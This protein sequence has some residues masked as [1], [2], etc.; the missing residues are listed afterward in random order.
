VQRIVQVKQVIFFASTVATTDVD[1]TM[2]VW[3]T[4]Y[5]QL[6]WPY[7]CRCQREI[8]RPRFCRSFEPVLAQ[9]LSASCAAIRGCFQFFSEHP[10]FCICYSTFIYCGSSIVSVVVYFADASHESGTESLR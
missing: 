6:T 5:L 9:A 3:A 10:V 1:L 2:S 7:L 8:F 4:C